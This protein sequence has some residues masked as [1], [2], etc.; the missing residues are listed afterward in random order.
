M[1]GFGASVFVLSTLWNWHEK[2]GWHV[3]PRADLLVNFVDIAFRLAL[4][5]TFGYVFGARMWRKMCL[6]DST[7]ERPNSMMDAILGKRPSVSSRLR[8]P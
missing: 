7:T 6:E 1:L 8:L 5:L 3:P 2:Y 4:W